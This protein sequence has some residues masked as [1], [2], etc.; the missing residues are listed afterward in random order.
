MHVSRMVIID[1]HSPEKKE[2]AKRK[3][4]R[5]SAKA[6]SV[7][8]R[9][10]LVLAAVEWLRSVDRWR[11]C[12]ESTSFARTSVQEA[13]W[14]RSRKHQLKRDKD[15]AIEPSSFCVFLVRATAQRHALPYHACFKRFISLIYLPPPP[16]PNLL[17]LLLLLFDCACLG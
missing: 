1:G 14:K 12:A 4:V 7:C 2:Q 11:K 6:R 8:V 10:I 9:S 3:M 5:S 17:V 15:S 16:P 13:L